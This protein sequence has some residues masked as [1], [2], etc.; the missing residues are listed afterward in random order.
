MSS[1]SGAGGGSS[2]SSGGG[3]GGSNGGLRAMTVSSDFAVVFQN[4]GFEFQDYGRLPTNQFSC[5]VDKA[6]EW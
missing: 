2:R 5:I 3:G 4:C 6:V 1:S